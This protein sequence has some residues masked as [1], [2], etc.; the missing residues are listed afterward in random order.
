[1]FKLLPVFLSEDPASALEDLAA[2]L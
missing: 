2:R 1:M